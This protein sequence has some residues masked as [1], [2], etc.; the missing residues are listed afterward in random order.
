[1]CCLD[2]CMLF[3][4]RLEGLQGCHGFLCNGSTRLS[5]TK[6]IFLLTQTRIWY[7]RRRGWVG[8]GGSY[9]ALSASSQAEV[10]LSWTCL[11]LAIGHKRPSSC[12][13]AAC[14][15][16]RVPL[17]VK[18]ISYLIYT[19]FYCE[20]WF[21]RL[22]SG[23]VLFNYK[24]CKRLL[25]SEGLLSLSLSTLASF[26]VCCHFFASSLAF[27]QCFYQ[28]VYLVLEQNLVTFLSYPCCV[29]E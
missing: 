24:H 7:S 25:R 27:I 2:Y 13:S 18:Y 3:M 4:W 23:N 15:S 8:G 1:M 21:Y 26:Q 12:M 19:R 10:D 14:L 28:S 16:S 17:F 29:H 11:G 22:R 9:I 20:Y 5:N 6:L